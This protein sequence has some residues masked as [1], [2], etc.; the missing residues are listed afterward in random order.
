MICKSTYAENLNSD[1]L[2]QEP[3]KTKSAS[4]M[5]MTE[6]LR[7]IDCNMF[8]KVNDFMNEWKQSMQWWVHLR[9]RALYANLRGGE[10]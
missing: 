1:Y 4:D 9:K 10:I 5:R 7:S 6:K 3:H 2:K 8:D